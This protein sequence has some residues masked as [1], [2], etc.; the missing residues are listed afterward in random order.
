MAN[1]DAFYGGLQA[2]NDMAETQ[3]AQRNRALVGNLAGAVVGGDPQAMAKVAAV[4]PRAA[5]SLEQTGQGLLKR[6][7]GAAQYLQKALQGGNPMEI[8]M[9]RQQIKPYMDTL[10][11]GTAYSLDMDPAQELAGIQGFLSQTQYLDPSYASGAAG[12]YGDL[13]S[14]IRSLKLLQEDPELAA[15]DR[16]RRQ[17]GGMVPKLVQTAQGYGWGIPGGEIQLAPMGGVAAQPGGEG[18]W[19]DTGEGSG[20]VRFNVDEFTPQ[21]QERVARTVSLMQQAGY[22]D[23]EIEQFVTSQLSN[24][25]TNIGRPQAGGIAQP[26]QSPAEQQRL[27]LAQA[28]D[29]RAQQQLGLAARAADRADRAEQRQIAANSVSGRT[30]N[31]GERNASGFYQRMVAANAEMKRLTDAGYDPTNLRDHLTVGSAVGNFLASDEG[32]QYNQAAMNWVRANLR[33]ESGAAIGV[34]EARQEIRN[35]F[36][37]PGDSPAV[38]QQKAKNRLV[39][40]QAMLQAAGRAAPRQGVQPQAAD[41][42]QSNAIPQRARNPQTGQ[43]IELR[44]GQWVPVQ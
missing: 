14:D 16:E 33:K 43:I 17:A 34:D 23:A 6:T 24:P 18:G 40:E 13:P 26:Y 29:A 35:Y 44:N 38:A 10:K 30:P 9:A 20:R 1:L 39:V 37:Q 27:A 36:P 8:A 12:P 5:S 15:L 19:T 25:V 7:R 4:D 21:Q 22:P 2:G 11:P 42:P 31:E 41:R 3:R 32:Q 28:S